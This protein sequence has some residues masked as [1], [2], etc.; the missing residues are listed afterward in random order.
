MAKPKKIKFVNVDTGN[1]DHKFD[2]LSSCA[3]YFKIHRSYI[4]RCLNHKIPFRQKWVVAY[5]DDDLVEEFVSKETKIKLIEDKYKKDL[6]NERK[7]RLSVEEQLSKYKEL[8]DQ[9]IELEDDDGTD[10]L[11]SSNLTESSKGKVVEGKLATQEKD[12]D[13][14]L[15]S[16]LKEVNIDKEEWE[17]A[18]VSISKWDVSSKYRN[19]NLKW[20]GQGKMFGYAIRKNK[21]IK[22]YNYSIKVELKPLINKDAIA[23]LKKHINNISEFK[24]N[25]YVPLHTKETGVLLELALYDAHFGKKAFM[26]EIGLDYGLREASASYLYS[27]DQIIRWSEAH[28]PEKIIFIVGQDLGH[29]DNIKGVTS[30]SGHILDLEKRLPF[31]YDELLATVTKAIYLC[32]S[33]AKTEVIWIPG[34]HDYFVSYALVRALKEHFRNDKHIEFDIDGKLGKLSRKARLWGNTLVGWTHEITTRQNSWGNEL[35]RMFPVE[36]GKSKFREWHHG[37][38]HKKQRIFT[39]GGVICRQIA[40]LSEIDKWH[41]DGLY[42]DAVPAGE[43]FLWSKDTGVYGNFDAYTHEF[44]KSLTKQ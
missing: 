13:K 12:S 30:G 9:T 24:Y 2:S 16:F 11:I 21:W 27:T 4:G 41:F 36:W 33:F 32:R 14:I 15:D 43:G 28:N 6:D 39:E 35:A 10:I 31:I 25:K 26:E 20:D 42:T 5:V 40:A 22:L 3:N 37:H 17:I 8:L 19:Q 34:N 38:K 29:V 1:I 23:S 44:N 18:K 7:I